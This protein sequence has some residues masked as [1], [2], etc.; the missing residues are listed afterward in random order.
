LCRYIKVFDHDNLSWSDDF[1]GTVEVDVA[2]FLD[3]ELHNKWVKLVAIES[4]EVRLRV[5]YFPG[6]VS[7]PKVRPYKLLNSVY[8]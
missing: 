5:K 1:M 6:A 7:A 2:E 3:G 4:G 8:P